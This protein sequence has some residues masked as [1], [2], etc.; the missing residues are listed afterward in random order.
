LT[1]L[2]L[3]LKCTNSTGN[4]YIIQPWG[5]WKVGA[6]SD[7]YYPIPSNKSN[8]K[9]QQSTAS[10]GNDKKDATTIIELPQRTRSMTIS[11]YTVYDQ[12]IKVLSDRYNYPNLQ[13]IKFVGHSAG[14]QMIHRYS[15]ISPIFDRTE[16][17]PTTSKNKDNN[18]NNNRI[19]Q[20]EFII[21]NPS[22]Y[23]Y[24]DE[25]RY[26][27]TCGTCTCSNNNTTTSVVIEA[28]IAA[29][30]SMPVGSCTCSES[31]TK[32]SQYL[33]IPSSLSNTFLPPKHRCQKKKKNKKKNNNKTTKIK[34]KKGNSDTTFNDINT[35]IMT[36]EQVSIMSI[37]DIENFNKSTTINEM[38][39]YDLDPSIIDDEA[40][41]PIVDN[42]TDSSITDQVS[43]TEWACYDN[44]YNAWPYGLEITTDTII[45]NTPSMMYSIPYLLQSGGTSLAPERYRQR[46]VTYLI[47]QNDTWYVLNSSI[48]IRKQRTIQ[49]WSKSNTVFLLLLIVQLCKLV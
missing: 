32:P 15:M 2:T 39:N 41:I 36:T 14:G 7:P 29:G 31:C 25:R 1:F 47:G 44:N 34:K 24:F 28:A 8:N 30:V 27:Y 35:D 9:K 10:G 48:I 21:A 40:C 23:T 42:V 13:N 19:I 22:S 26:P 3:L 11:S 4:T 12:F 16:D 18:N 5:D 49:E 38:E 6:Q 37:I 46:N 20:Y 17:T 43:N 45:M 33:Q